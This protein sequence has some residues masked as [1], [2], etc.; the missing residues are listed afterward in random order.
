[1]PHIPLMNNAENVCYAGAFSIIPH[2]LA[3]EKKNCLEKYHI[4]ERLLSTVIHF[5][6]LFF[7]FVSYI[8]RLIHDYIILYLLVYLKQ[9]NMWQPVFV[10]VYP[11]RFG[12]FF[13]DLWACAINCVPLH[14]D[15]GGSFRRLHRHRRLMS[16]SI[17]NMAPL[18]VSRVVCKC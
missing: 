7:C 3:E 1:M 18:C 11:T 4:T 13:F 12:N 10:M 6:L 17:Y 5:R 2:K 16:H 9:E 14:T 15:F 8:S